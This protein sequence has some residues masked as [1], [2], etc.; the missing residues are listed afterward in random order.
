MLTPATPLLGTLPPCDFAAGDAE[1]PPVGSPDRPLTSGCVVRSSSRPRAVAHCPTF[2][3]HTVLAL[4]AACLHRAQY[5]DPHRVVPSE[6]FQPCPLHKVTFIHYDKSRHEIINASYQYLWARCVCKQCD[7][8]C[9]AIRTSRTC[10]LELGTSLFCLEL[11]I[12]LALFCYTFKRS[13]I[14]QDFSRYM[15][16]WWWCI[17]GHRGDKE[18]DV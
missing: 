9:P 3:V 18:G 15:F 13:S 2:G 17:V 8:H 14:K 7:M 11:W 1:T 16:C 5:T 12:N 10:N 4:V 6:Y